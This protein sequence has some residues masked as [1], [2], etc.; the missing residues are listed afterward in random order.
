MVTLYIPPAASKTEAETTIK[1]TIINLKIKSPDH[2]LIVTGDFNHCND[3]NIPGLHQYIDCPTREAKTLDLFLCNIKSAYKCLKQAPLV[4]SD[5]C[6]L[7]MLPKYKPVVKRVKPVRKKVRV[8]G[9]SVCEQLQDCFEITDWNVFTD[10][11]ETVHEL[12]ESGAA[13]NASET[14]EVYLWDCK[15]DDDDDD[16]DDDNNNDDYVNDDDD[17]F[18]DDDDHYGGG[19]NDDDDDTDHNDDVDYVKE[20]ALSVNPIKEFALSFNTLG[21]GVFPKLQ[22]FRKRSFF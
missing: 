15:T 22:P 17:Y 8:W 21:N 9:D 14:G 18:N 11:C 6:M 1:D 7:L 19:N 2:I 3:I 20:F 4:S 10:S 12:N 13:E 16:D 5:H